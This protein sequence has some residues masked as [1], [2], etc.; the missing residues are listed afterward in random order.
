MTKKISLF[1]ILL[2]LIVISSCKKDKT[3][4]PNE[5]EIIT[6]L[7]YTLTPVGGGTTVTLTFKDLDGDGPD[8]AIVTGGTLLANTVYNGSMELLNETE[9]P[10]EDVT[11]EIQD[12]DEEHQFFFESTVPG[13]SVAYDDQ[14]G[15]MNPVGL[16]TKITTGNQTGTG[17]LKINLIHEPIKSAAG[18]SGGDITNAG[19]ESDIEVTFDVNVAI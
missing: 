15:D 11:V 18:V 14:D 16:K 6:T 5:E 4:I 3:V 9:T 7:N 12:E 1:A 17:T 10:A 19:G 13:L 8:T 2:S